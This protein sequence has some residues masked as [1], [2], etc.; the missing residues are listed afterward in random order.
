MIRPDI[1]ANRKAKKYS[2]RVLMA[3]ALWGG[4]RLPLF[5]WTPR[6]LWG[7]RR[8]VLRAF[9]ARVGR[10]VHVY[11]SARIFAPWDLELGDACAIGD[12]AVIYNLGRISI[13]AA[14]TISQQAHLCAGTHDFR[15]PAMPLL[16]P[17]IDIGAGA[18]ICADAFIGPGVK[19]GGMAIIGARAVVVRD[20][21]ADTIVVG[22]PARV[23]GRREVR[24]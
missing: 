14:A 2:P 20:V 11:P 16:K 6:P 5:A 1:I 19:V 23:V 12:R 9:G 13:G 17:P 10:D 21:G 24:S 15:D 3:R 8:T 4:L 18:W 22:N 7:W